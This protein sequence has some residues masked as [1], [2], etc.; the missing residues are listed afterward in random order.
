MILLVR[1]P[2][3]VIVSLYHQRRGRHGGYPGSLAEFLDERVGG[4]ESLLR[5]YD[6][7]ADN[8]A[9]LARRAGRALRGP[10]RPARRT[11]CAGS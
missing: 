8:A 5:F 3:D 1:D 9:Y 10:P 4:F 2:R 6:A 11:S 7:W